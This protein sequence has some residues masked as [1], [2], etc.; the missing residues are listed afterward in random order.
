LFIIN[1]LLAINAAFEGSFW[2]S[3]SLIPNE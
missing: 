2:C 1:E 3:K